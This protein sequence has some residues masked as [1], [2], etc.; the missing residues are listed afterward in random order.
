MIEINPPGS[1]ATAAGGSGTCRKMGIEKTIHQIPT[2]RKDSRV[3]SESPSVKIMM[4]LIARSKSSAEVADCVAEGG[5]AVDV[6]IPGYVRKQRVVEDVPGSE[7]DP[8]DDESE[9]GDEPVTGADEDEQRHTDRSD[10]DR[11]SQ[12]TLLSPSQ[13]RDRPEDRRQDGNHDQRYRQRRGPIGGGLCGG[14]KCP[15]GDLAVVHGQDGSEDRRRE[16]RVCPVVE[17]PGTDSRAVFLVGDCSVTVDRIA[18]VRSS[19]STGGEASW[20]IPQTREI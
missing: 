20:T 13:V 14:A 1:V 5:D 11:R 3:P 10:Q 6:L 17:G 18:H 4:M 9:R 7:S 19:L 12:K 16:C 8:G 2:D 15:P